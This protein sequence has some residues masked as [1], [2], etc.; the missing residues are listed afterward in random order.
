MTSGSSTISPTRMYGLRLEKGS[1]KMTWAR[2]R[3]ARS[4]GPSRA[5]MSVPS[6]TMRP[7]LMGTRCRVARPSVVLPLPD[8]PTRAT[9]SPVAMS[10]STSLTAAMGR[11]AKNDVRT[12]EADAETLDAQE[13][14]I[15]RAPGWSR[16]RL[17]G[18]LGGSGRRSGPRP[19]RGTRTG[20]VQQ[21][22]AGRVPGLPAGVSSSGATVRQASKT[23]G[24]RGAKRQPG[25]L[26]AQV[27]RGARQEARRLLVV[28]AG[29]ARQEA[30]RVGVERLAPGPPRPS[31]ARA[32]GPRRRP[33]CGRTGR[34]PA[35]G[36]G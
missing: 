11:V 25:E 27:G 14:L 23:C 3:K 22:A 8:S 34:W 21:Q 4:S 28:Q 31:R 29:D 18:G 10:R 16:C 5:P 17:G 19:S 30:L 13:R 2:C 24:Q 26:V 9:V 35:P 6:K 36:R 15:R 7:L 32:A 1:W 12:I 33:R 20:R